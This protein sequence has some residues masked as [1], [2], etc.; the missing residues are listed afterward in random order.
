MNSIKIYQSRQ[1]K[2][3]LK[4]EN[5]KKLLLF[6]C[7]LQNPTLEDIRKNINWKKKIELTTLIDNIEE[8]D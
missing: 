7:L 1:G 2:L 8:E 5:E 3:Y 6:I 4:K